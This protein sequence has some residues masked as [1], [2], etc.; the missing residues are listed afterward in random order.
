MIHGIKSFDE[1]NKECPGWEFV[2]MALFQTGFDAEESVL[3]AS[4]RLGAELVFEACIL[5]D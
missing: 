3:T 5:Y 4:A 2:L 1:V